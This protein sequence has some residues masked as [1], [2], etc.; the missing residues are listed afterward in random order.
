MN[1]L[2][3][4]GA[5][6]AASW[7]A[8]P[9]GATTTGSVTLV[10]TPDE[11]VCSENTFFGFESFPEGTNLSTLSFPGVSFALNNSQPWRVGDLEEFPWLPKWPSGQYMT[12]GTHH[13]YVG[14][15]STFTLGGSGRIDFPSGASTFSLLASSGTPVFLEAYD[16]TDALLAV[17]GPSPQ[18]IG[19]GTMH[20][21]KVTSTTADIAYV[22]AHDSGNFFL[23]DSFC[24]D[25]GL[26]PTTTV[27][28]SDNDPSVYGE[29][30]NFT[31]TVSS[32]SGT[33]TGDVEFFDGLTSLGTDTLDGNGDATFTSAALGA[34]T[35]AI[36]ARYL[37]SP[38]YE[39]SAGS[40]DQD[41]D[42]APTTVAFLGP[43][44]VMIG[45]SP[46]FGAQLGSTA[47]G[48]LDARDVEFALE[49]N[50]SATTS[51]ASG[52]ASTTSIAPTV[53]QA[54]AMV[55]SVDENDNCLGADSAAAADVVTVATAGDAAT[56]GGWY[57]WKDTGA[58]KRVNFGFT[59][60][61][62]KKTGV[63]RGNLLLMNSEHWRL[64]ATIDSYTRESSTGKAGGSGTLLE[65]T[66]TD[67]GNPRNVSYMIEFTDVASGKNGRKSSTVDGFRLA[68]MSYSA[69]TTPTNSS[70]RPLMGGDIQLR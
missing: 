53:P 43:Y 62:D 51:S 27:V 55:V 52:A 23:L 34:G 45:T 49:A 60:R 17:A 69:S 46:T 4:V 32:G 39:E 2:I 33:P 5:L 54:A 67:W 12:Q 63:I 65:W 31:A 11:Y 26:I 8:T 37:G 16:A 47:P 48:C 64:K 50:T 6:I 28:V 42:K 57:Q 36:T 20:E 10:S 18:N 29:T 15:V 41:V 3:V 7:V 68:S 35:H 38:P 13:A 24:T 70:L 61:K 22:I 59:T 25:A 66:G 40:L 14:D 1:V 9:A 21:L 56:G 30:V 44:L 58:G 19:T